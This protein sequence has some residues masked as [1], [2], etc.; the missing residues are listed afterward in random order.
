MK[1]IYN[2]AL[3]PLRVWKTKPSSSQMNW[4]KSQWMVAL[5]DCSTRSMS[6]ITI[7]KTTPTHST[8]MISTVCFN[9]LLV[10]V[11]AGHLFLSMIVV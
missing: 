9:L 5:P 11:K 8:Q 6:S 10:N 7:W 2:L 4:V 3:S 1:L